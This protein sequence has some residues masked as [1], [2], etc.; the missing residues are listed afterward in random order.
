M[1]AIYV[2]R[3]PLTLRAMYVGS[4]DRPAVRYAEHVSAHTRQTVVGHWVNGVLLDHELPV[5]EIIELVPDGGDWQA[6]EDHWIR[7]LTPPLNVRPNRGWHHTDETR[8]KMRGRN[9]TH[10]RTPA[11]REATRQ[12][13]FEQHA[14]RRNGSGTV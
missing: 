5:F 7:A 12:R 2:L 11:M 6:V 4:S 3:E 1:R 9:G 8:A 10:V 14:R 13:A